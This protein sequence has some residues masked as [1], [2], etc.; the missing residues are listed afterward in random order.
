MQAVV[1]NV[2]MVAEEFPKGPVS[3]SMA[4]QGGAMVIKPLVKQNEMQQVS[5]F[6]CVMFSSCGLPETEKNGE[7]WSDEQCGL[8]SLMM[9]I[10]DAPPGD[11][12]QKKKITLK[13][14]NSKKLTEALSLTASHILE[15]CSF[16]A[17]LS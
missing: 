15:L 1:W 6:N 4:K 12:V 14:Q 10:F 16:E 9:D 11:V 13:K 3:G 7:Q 17:A 2:D 5:L 8:P